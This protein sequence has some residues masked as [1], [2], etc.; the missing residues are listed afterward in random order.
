MLNSFQLLTIFTK[1]SILDVWQG[2]EYPSV[3]DNED[4]NTKGKMMLV[5]FDDFEGKFNK[6]MGTSNT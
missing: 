1:S 3:I 5:D 6:Y 2:S 4:N